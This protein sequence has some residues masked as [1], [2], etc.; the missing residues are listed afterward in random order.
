MSDFDLLVT[1]RVVLT[2]RFTRSPSRGTRCLLSAH[3]GHAHLKAVANRSSEALLNAFR[4]NPNAQKSHKYNKILN[5]GKLEGF[6][7]YGKLA[8]SGSVP[9]LSE[10]F[11]FA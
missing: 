6:K 1:G 2:D 7:G 4:S 3:C 9:F 10:C 8:F 5:I 11:E